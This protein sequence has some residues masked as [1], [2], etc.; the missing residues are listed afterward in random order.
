[1]AGRLADLTRHQ[2]RQIRAPHICEDR[3]E[4][5]S[6]IAPALASTRL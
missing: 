2:H 6:S 1:M 5:R 3:L 4:A